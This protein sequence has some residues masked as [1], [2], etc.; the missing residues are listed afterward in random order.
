MGMSYGKSNEGS[1]YPNTTTGGAPSFSEQ[2][3][4]PAGGCVVYKWLVGSEQAPPPGEASALFAY[5]SFVNFETDVNAGLVGPQIIYNRGNMST[6]MAATREFPILYNIYNETTSFL[7][8]TNVQLK[9]TNSS[10]DAVTLPYASPGNQSFWIPE[11]VNM[12]TVSLSASDAPAIHTINGYVF[13][14]GPPFEMC[15]GDDV[16]CKSSFAHSY[17]YGSASHVF[18]LHGNNVFYDNRWVVA[19]SA[20]DGEMFT[21]KMEAGLPDVWQVVCHVQNHLSKGMVAGY[22]FWEQGEC[23]LVSLA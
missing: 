3:A 2:E 14:N 21:L 8:A 19:K 9:G 6:A 4:V 11:L 12:P 15:A 7:A 16:T 1:D 18:H 17:A 13:S 5:H 22:R 20:N 23:S 10:N